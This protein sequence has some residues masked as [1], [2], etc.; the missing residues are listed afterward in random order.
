MPTAITTTWA[1]SAGDTVDAPRSRAGP[2]GRRP[3]APHSTAPAI[4]K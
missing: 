4:L 3:Q 1:T 2:G